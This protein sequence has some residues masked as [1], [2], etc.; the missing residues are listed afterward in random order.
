ML[1][2]FDWRS[3]VDAALPDFALQR[4]WL[5]REMFACSD[6]VAPAAGFGRARPGAQGEA[7]R[8]SASGG[9]E[10]IARVLAATPFRASGVVQAG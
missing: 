6:G 1:G 7:Q 4:R 5:V 3:G 8:L 2:L 9:C 10:A